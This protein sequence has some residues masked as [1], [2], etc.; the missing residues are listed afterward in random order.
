[1]IELPDLTTLDADAVRQ[2]QAMVADRLAQLMPAVDVRRGVVADLVVGPI[3]I[4]VA[5]IS[6]ELDDARVS[7][8]LKTASAASTTLDADL[9]DNI[10]SNFGVVRRT[11]LNAGGSIRLTMSS[12]TP[13]T[14]PTGTAFIISGYRFVTDRAFSARSPSDPTVSDTDI[15]LV[16]ASDGTYYW[17]IEV[18]SDEVLG[19]PVRTGDRADPLV[20][21]T[22][23]VVAV[24]ETDFFTGVAAE[25]VEELLVSIQDGISVPTAG[26]ARGLVSLVREVV[27]AAAASVVAYGDAEQTRY[28]EDLPGV[29]GSRVDVYVR[30][31]ELPEISSI[32]KEA[33][34]IG[35]DAAGLTVWQVG[36]TRDDLPGFYRIVGIKTADSI[37]EDFGVEPLTLA[38]G[39]DPQDEVDIRLSSQASFTRYQ[40]AVVT[41]SGPVGAIGDKLDFIVTAAQ[42]SDLTAITDALLSRETRPAGVDILVRGAVPCDVQIDATIKISGQASQDRTTVV[43]V[44]AKAINGLSFVDELS[45]DEIATR[46][47]GQLPAGHLLVSLSGLGRITRPDRT[48][49]IVRGPRRLIVPDEAALGVS[50]R[51]VAFFCDPADIIVNFEVSRSA[52]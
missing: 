52:G 12:A 27:P 44:L 46:I 34:C 8:S 31:T 24:A 29:G 22:G 5:A 40:T 1:M 50:Y 43:N 10:L 26:T 37:E 20:P 23:L 17:S 18:T 38:F 33:T 21:I 48:E 19:T 15:T 14:L 11:P 3:G 9:I 42:Q 28:H 49:A 16:A 36:L 39:S 35:P 51:T 2:A 13:I 41:F 7:M 4:L 47:S 45:T 6:A 30:T 32:T 25:T